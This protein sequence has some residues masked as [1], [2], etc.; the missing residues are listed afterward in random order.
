MKAFADTIGLRMAHF[1]FGML[2]IVYGQIKLVIMC[3]GFAAILGPRSVRI[4]ITPIPISVIN[5]K[6]LI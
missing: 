2:N 6:G 1:G 5:G 3:F 4:R